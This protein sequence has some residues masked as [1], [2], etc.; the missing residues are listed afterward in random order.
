MEVQKSEIPNGEFL[1]EVVID[2]QLLYLTLKLLGRIMDSKQ[3]Y[4]V[5]ECN[6]G[7][8]PTCVQL[9]RSQSSSFGTCYKTG[10]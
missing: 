7:P 8:S 2:S 1:A 6:T 4:F 3:V 5:L 9:F 10:N